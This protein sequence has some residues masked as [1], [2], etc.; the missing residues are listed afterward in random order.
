MIGEGEYM[1]LQMCSHPLL[2]CIPRVVLSCL[3]QRGG[4]D[5]WDVLGWFEVGGGESI[6]GYFSGRSAYA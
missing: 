2:C 1:V 6:L 3:G 4:L 5:Y